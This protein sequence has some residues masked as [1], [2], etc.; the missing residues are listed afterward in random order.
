MRAIY[1][2]WIALAF[3][4]LALAGCMPTDVGYMPPID[5]DGDCTTLNANIKVR[6]ASDGRALP[7]KCFTVAGD[8]EVIGSDLTDL[9]PLIYLRQANVL[10][11]QGNP[12]LRTL[13]GLDGVQVLQH[14]EI[15]NN[16]M[17]GDVS[18]LSRTDSVARVTISKNP[19]LVSLEGL[20]SLREVGAGGM[21]IID[22]DGLDELTDF[23]ALERVEGP[24]RVA[25]NSGLRSLQTF[26]RLD[27]VGK[28]EV[29]GNTGLERVGFN[30]TSVGGDLVISDNRDMIEIAG[31]GDLETVAGSLKIE[32]NP[33]LGITNGFTPK[34]RSVAGDVV[35]TDN[36]ALTDIYDIAANLY[37]V[38]GSVLA[39]GNVALSECRADDLDLIEEVGTFLDIGA[40]GS[41][42]E[43]CH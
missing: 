13:A 22:N 26:R 12:E 2:R 9:E 4:T 7:Q 16:P 23:E 5:I 28:L 19:Q 27:S 3:A 24:L 14:V 42:F 11:I 20:R 6:S 30:V 36:V 18:G 35:I 8:V 1:D 25:S 38:G 33:V 10:R 40:N 17:L 37:S 31:F 41:F 15:D 34:F 29:T 21:A 39:T 43:P 32:R